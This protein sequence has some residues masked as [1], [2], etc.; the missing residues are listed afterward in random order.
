MP[1]GLETAPATRWLAENVEGLT[2]PF[3]F[4]LIAAGGSNLTYSVADERGRRVALRR[5]PEGRRL[6][7]AHDV[8]REVRILKA[9]AGSAVPVPEIFGHCDDDGVIGAP[10]YVMNFVDGLILRGR[11]EAA[12]LDRDACRRATE[13]LIDVHVALHAI[14]VD[15][16][17][18]GT[19]AKREGYVLRQLTRWRKQAER[20]KTRDVPLLEQL[21]ETL[22]SRIPPERGPTALVHGDYRFDNTVLGTNR[23]VIAVL[24]WELCTLG[25]PVADFCWSLLYW[26]DPGD[27]YFFLNSPPTLH[28]AFD[29]RDDIAQLYAQRSGRDLDAL[30]FFTTFG[31]W[32]MACIV[33]GVYARLQAGSGGGMA[34]ENVAAVADRVDQL[35]EIAA[36]A[37]RRM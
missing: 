22:V 14:D 2:P 15:E 37:A 30:P 20:S 6:A 36:D 35:L 18:L 13:S 17:G 1:R 26:A 21:H 19:L 9:L 24:D 31:F 32:K 16:I 29:R 5:P 10:F 23:N 28:A 33:E 7:T 12:K 11:E 4:D 27:P 34:T 25:D 8:G 3:T